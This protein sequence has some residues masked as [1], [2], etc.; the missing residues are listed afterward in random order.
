MKKI[1]LFIWLYPFL[2][3][4]QHNK[5]SYSAETTPGV[6]TVYVQERR[7]GENFEA[8][9]AKIIKN[10]SVKIESREPQKTRDELLEKLKNEGGYLVSENINDYGSFRSIVLNFRI[11]SKS[12]DEYLNWISK[13][14]PVKNKDVS[15][16]DITPQYIDTE[17]R[18]KNKKALEQR[19]LEL[20]KQAK[21][22]DEILKIEREL[23]KIRSEI[24]TVQGQLKYWNKQVAFSEL[25]VIIEAPHE[26]Q[27]HFLSDL[28]SAF[29]EGIW[30]FYDFLIGLVYLWPFVLLAGIL[31]LWLRLRKSRS[32]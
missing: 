14:Y 6:K 19:Y 18:L 12:F 21:N 20:L 1:F 27:R 29:K 24:E 30:I 3:A 17:A 25:H 26:R 31:L 32:K 4:C 9:E 23:A 2:F 10:G 13:N 5:T 8:A 7:D 11:P 22:V 16:R 28:K 15:I